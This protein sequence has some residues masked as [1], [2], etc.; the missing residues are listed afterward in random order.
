VQAIA[1]R[2]SEP[3]V[4]YQ[5]CTR[6]VGMFRPGGQ[7]HL[8]KKKPSSGPTALNIL[9]EPAHNEVGGG[10]NPGN[11]STTR[12][13]P[14]AGETFEGPLFYNILMRNLVVHTF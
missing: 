14:E 8:V 13:R 6:T 12:H 5:P 7:C 1:H 11:V 4:G 3:L 10:F 2:C 9:A